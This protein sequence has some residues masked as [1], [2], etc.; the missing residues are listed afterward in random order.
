MFTP[1][2]K[3]YHEKCPA[4]ISAGHLMFCC[5]PCS[6]EGK[7]LPSVTKS[8][9]PANVDHI[10]EDQYRRAQDREPQD[11]ITG[12][13]GLRSTGAAYRIGFLCRAVRGVA[14]A[15]R[16]LCHDGELRACLV[17]VIGY[18]AW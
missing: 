14:V 16:L 8:S 9:F 17:A 5:D 13:S 10:E 6:F 15:A 1:Y 11:H 12:I 4:G 3:V 7:W 2:G 18:T